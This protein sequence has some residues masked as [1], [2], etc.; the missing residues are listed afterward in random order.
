LK[1]K[2]RVG[3][4]KGGSSGKGSDCER[5][6]VELYLQ[7]RA[8]KLSSS[9]VHFS[10]QAKYGNNDKKFFALLSALV[11]LVA[12]SIKFT[13]KTLFSAAKLLIKIF[14]RLF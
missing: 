1:E 7:K 12:H 13:F 6:G 11:S 4:G 5:S 9:P 14:T 3:G 8:S 2:R 10:D